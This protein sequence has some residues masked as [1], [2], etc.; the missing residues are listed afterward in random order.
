MAS[1]VV[2]GKNDEVKVNIKHALLL[3][4]AS[5][6]ISCA[7]Y[8]ADF[9][10]I[11]LRIKDK[12]LDVEYADTFELRAT[13]LMHRKS[14]CQQCGMLF[15]YS[16][17]RV[18]SMWMKNT[19]IPLDVAFIDKNGIIVAIRAMQPHDLTS[20]AAPSPVLYALEM[21]QGW[22]AN[23]EINIGDRVIIGTNAISGD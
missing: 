10:S 23:N 22:F 8:A 3:C 19:F 7:L 14:L 17:A 9:G 15:R 18:A 16:S 13:G 6:L 4:V 11:T 12:T 21:N 5:V 20:I 2:D 1:P